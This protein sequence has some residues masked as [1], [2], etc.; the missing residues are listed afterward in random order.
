[1]IRKMPVLISV[2]L[3][4]LFMIES[5]KGQD[6][7]DIGIFE[8]A[9]TDTLV[10]KA[11]PNF[12]LASPFYITSIT[13]TIKWPESS[14]VTQL[15][16]ITSSVNSYFNIQLQQSSTSGGYRYQVYGMVSQK[17]VNW[18]AGQEYAI[19]E[20]K[21]NYTGGDCTTFEISDDVYTYNFLNGGYWFEVVGANRTGIRYVPTVSLISQGG[22]VSSD[23]TICLGS[24]TS[25]MTLSGQ[26]GTVQSWQKKHD[27]FGWADIAGTAGLTQYTATPDSSG[28]YQYRVRVQRGSCDPAFSLAAVI[29]VEPYSVWSGSADTTWHNPMNWNACGVPIQSRDAVVPAV[30]GGRYPTVVTTGTCKSLLIET[31][32]RVKVLNT[33]SFTVGGTT[34][35]PG[36]CI[37]PVSGE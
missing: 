9:I 21:V 7:V 28:T 22:M 35:S 18:S 16:N 10:I 3:I 36:H 27:A 8:S 1:M 32:A 19:M 23:E 29:G 31:G 34:Y 37:R 2:L 6:K 12:N 11:R 26:K 25:V 30:P 14:N 33:S 15:L 24:S 5:L 4:S 20:V 13:F 17:F